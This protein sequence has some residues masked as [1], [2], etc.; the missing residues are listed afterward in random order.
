[1]S[2]LARAANNPRYLSYYMP[3]LNWLRQYKAS[4]ITGDLIA[5]LTVASVY[6]PMVLSFADS[7]A[8]VPPI[9]GLYAFV[10]NPLMYAIFGSSPA[11]MVGP[12]ATAS[13]LVG[14]VVKR[15]ADLVNGDGDPVLQ[16]R[17]CGIIAGMTG[18]TI[19]A[20]GLARVG[21]LDS[22]FSRPF[23]RGFISAVGFVI[24]VEQLVPQAGLVEE[25]KRAGVSHG[26]SVE[27][28]VF[29]ARN[30]SDAH[31]LTATIA[32]STF[33]ALMVLR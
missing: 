11:L 18:A 20:A 9:N 22:V 2:C 3:C 1:M 6:L 28:L 12:D 30:L 23:L 7:L 32:A 4:Y 15:S 5:A 8:H 25:A 33:V 31:V 21:F 10:F 19:L 29:L 16:A 17:V 26:S 13:L 24:F 27:K 14:T